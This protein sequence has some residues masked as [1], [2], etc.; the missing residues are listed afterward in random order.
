MPSTHGDLA[1]LD[2]PVAQALL[3]SQNLARVAYTWTDGTPRVVPI[4][5]HWTGSEL[6][7]GS[8]VDAPKV[9]V[10][11]ERPAVAVTID[12]ARPGGAGWRVLLLRGTAT[13]EIVEGVVPEY[14]AA[15]R[16]YLGEAGA[17]AWLAQLE[18]LRL[19]RMARIAVR[20]AWVGLLDFETRFPSALER[21]MEVA[22]PPAGGATRAS[23]SRS[24]AGGRAPRSSV[25]MAGR[26]FRSG[27]TSRVRP[28]GRG[29]APRRGRR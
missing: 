7:L 2:E 10:L 29:A 25:R 11:R 23:R 20:P 24:S 19:T 4:W 5:F 26:P 12:D 8:P 1:L 21:A 17:E 14:A 22:Q 3:H 18:P 16:R 28:P 15:A 13:V 6:V 27:R 9:R